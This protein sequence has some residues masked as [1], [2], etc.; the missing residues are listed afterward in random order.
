[1]FDL[2][3]LERIF[4]QSHP[5]THARDHDTKR[6][7]RSTSISEKEEQ[8]VF[9]WR[10]LGNVSNCVCV[11]VCRTYAVGVCTHIKSVSRSKSSPDQHDV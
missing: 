2:L 6:A 4:I 7:T 3:L 8:L 11:C 5:L 9:E 1:M 10:K